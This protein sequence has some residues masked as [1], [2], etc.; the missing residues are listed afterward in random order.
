MFFFSE[1]TGEGQGLFRLMRCVQNK[2]STKVNLVKIFF[3][4]AFP[5]MVNFNHKGW[6]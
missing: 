3:E 2:L 5:G 1:N 4:A 6:A